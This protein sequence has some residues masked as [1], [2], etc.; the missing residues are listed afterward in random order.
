MRGKGAGLLVG[1]EEG[2][3][4]DLSSLQ[5]SS[6]CDLLTYPG[7]TIPGCGAATNH[8]DS[9]VGDRQCL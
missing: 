1:E 9:S 8:F 2:A 5:G 4:K 7:V 3:Y 6:R